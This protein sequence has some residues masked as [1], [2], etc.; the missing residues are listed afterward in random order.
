MDHHQLSST[1]RLFIFSFFM[2]SLI[3]FNSSIGTFPRAQALT[4]FNIDAVGDWGCNS[5][6]VSTVTNIKGKS[7]LSRY[8]HWV[9]ILIPIQ[10]SV[11][12]IE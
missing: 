12:L 11:G 2:G 3:F 4:D 7:S 6:T 1:F 9:T 5:D 10:Q 8:L